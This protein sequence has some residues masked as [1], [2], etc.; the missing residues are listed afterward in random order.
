MS[1]RY[2]NVLKTIEEEKNHVNE[3]KIRI[4]E[5][6]NQNSKLME[7]NSDYLMRLK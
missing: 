5:L 4:S 3:L 7:L 2:E 1:L 6:E